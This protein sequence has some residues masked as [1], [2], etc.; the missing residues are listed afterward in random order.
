MNNELELIMSELLNFKVP[1]KWG[2]VFL[3]LKPI[4]SWINELT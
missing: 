2:D 4:M 3:S 1:T